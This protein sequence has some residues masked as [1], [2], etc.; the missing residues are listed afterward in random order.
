VVESGEKW[1]KV[2]SKWSHFMKEGEF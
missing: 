1:Y 2:E